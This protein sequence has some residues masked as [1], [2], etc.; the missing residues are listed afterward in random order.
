[1][2]RRPAFAAG[3]WLFAVACAASL[4]VAPATAAI[5]VRCSASA[6]SINFGVY[7]PL[8]GTGDASV[9]TLMVNCSG[10]GRGSTRITI[11]VSL[12]PGLSGNY[13]VR[14]MLS[15]ASA[16]DYNIYWDPQHTIVMGDGTGG[17]YSGTAGPITIF[18]GGTVQATGTMYGYVPARQNPN[19]GSYVD[20]ITVTVTY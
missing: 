8:A 3:A 5:V 12:S 20:V 11:G 15:G 10:S 18:N 6:G 13:G 17:S 16:L 1:M 2:N 9:G 19:P 7:N 4:V 14:K